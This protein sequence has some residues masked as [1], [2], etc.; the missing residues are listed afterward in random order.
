MEVEETPGEVRGEL[1]VAPLSRGESSV[2][3]EDEDDTEG[4]LP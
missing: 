4:N 2:E 1:D 3:E